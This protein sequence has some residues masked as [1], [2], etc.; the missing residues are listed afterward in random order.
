MK[1]DDFENGMDYNV[2]NEIM[3]DYMFEGKIS[4]EAIRKRLESYHLGILK[5]TAL[6]QKIQDFIEHT[7]TKYKA[8]GE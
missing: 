5:L 8:E 4:E 3:T 7:Y 6:T 2:V 1:G